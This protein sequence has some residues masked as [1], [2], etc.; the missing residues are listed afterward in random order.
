MS[1]SPEPENPK[2]PP[3][4]IHIHI[5]IH[6][7]IHLH[8]TRTSP[9]PSSCVTCK[10]TYRTY[11]TSRN[12]PHLLTALTIPTLLCFYSS[13]LCSA[14]LCSVSDRPCFLP[15]LVHTWSHIQLIFPTPIL[16]LSSYVGRQIMV[17][18]R[19]SSNRNRIIGHSYQ[20][21][22]SAVGIFSSG[23]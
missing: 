13:L 20:G 19:P 17:S 4:H 14:L 3:I 5:H 23:S 1:H 15:P 22:G 11:N 2:I 18:V 7:D 10:Y 16:F 9:I 21:S 8:R 6:I 12:P